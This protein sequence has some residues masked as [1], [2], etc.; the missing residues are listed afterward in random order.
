[1]AVVFF[2]NKRSYTKIGSS[3]VFSNTQN[4]GCGV[5]LQHEEWW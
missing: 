3:G 5:F 2:T 1:M 4:G